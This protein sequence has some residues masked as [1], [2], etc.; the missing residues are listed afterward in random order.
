MFLFAIY[1][2][3]LQNTTQYWCEW[4]KEAFIEETIKAM[5]YITPYF[6]ESRD[7][8]KEEIEESNLWEKVTD[9][10]KNQL[11]RW[12]MQ[13]LVYWEKAWEWSF[14]PPHCPLRPDADLPKDEREEAELERYSFF[15][16]KRVYQG[17]S[18]K[19]AL[20][21]WTI[22]DKI[23]L[24]HAFD[25]MQKSLPEVFSKPEFGATVLKWCEKNNYSK[26]V[27]A[28]GEFH[29]YQKEI[30]KV[31]ALEKDESF[32]YLCDMFS[33]KDKKP[34][35]VKNNRKFNVYCHQEPEY[36]PLLTIN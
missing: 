2:P 14:E 1:N 9:I 3:Y 25:L 8:L 21:L 10:G 11:V 34:E 4:H 29:A 13:I 20:K 16:P 33:K 22:S 15:T 6:I 35:P 17:R 23:W 5:N 24:D 18:V 28:R 32:V 26:P 12:P 19:N 7:L 27:F 30:N 31:I 36:S